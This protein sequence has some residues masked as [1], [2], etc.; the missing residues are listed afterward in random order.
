MVSPIE[1][2]PVEVFDTIASDLDLPAYNALRLT[3]RQLNLLSFSTYAKGYFSELTATLGSASLDRLLNVS[4]HKYFSNAVTVL[5]IRLLNHRDYKLLNKISRVGIFP[6]PKRF[7]R[8]SGVRPETTTQEATLYDDVTK[9]EYPRCIVERLACSLRGFSSLETIRFRAH[10][11]EPY[12]WRSTMM[13]EGDQ[14]FRTKCFQAVLD[15]LI[16]SDIRLKE[17]SMAKEKRST[18]LSKCANLPYPTLQLPFRS[19]QALH[20]RFVNL[21]SLTL[22]IVSAYNGDARIPGW[23]NALTNLIATAPSIKSLALSLDRHNRI[24]HYSAAIIH[25]LALSCRFSQLQSFQLV[26]CSLHEEDLVAFVTAHERSLC[27]LVFSDI[28]VLT[29]SWPALLMSLKEAKELQCLRLA[30]LEGT[31]S[32]LLFRRRD[33]ERLKIT[34]D[35]AKAERAMSVMLDDLIAACNSESDL[36]TTSIDSI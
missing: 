29:G 30:S 20:H 17:F 12:G 27:Q 32:P 25:S 36:P 24:S 15:A 31:K 1:H 11:S 5:D 23:Q 9:S 6:I 3:S 18:T 26:N 28:R 34:L 35:A 2:L 16:K 14:L 19:L 10:H 13:P 33:K 22:S 21:E 8:V 7:P 4:T